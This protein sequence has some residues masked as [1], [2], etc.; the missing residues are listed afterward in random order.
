MLG[1][2]KFIVCQKTN[3]S[4]ESV[5]C[6]LLIFFRFMTPESTSEGNLLVSFRSQD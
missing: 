1:M 5:I 3:T 2:R 6:N 4:A